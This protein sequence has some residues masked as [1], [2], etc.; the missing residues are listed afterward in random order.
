MSSVRSPAELVR[1]AER[2]GRYLSEPTAHPYLAWGRLGQILRAQPPTQA[3][4]LACHV[5]RA[6]PGSY[7]QAFGGGTLAHLIHHH[8]PTLIDW[9]EREA[10][11]DVDFLDALSHAWIARDD[12]D[13]AM[14]ARL[15][16]ATGSLIRIV[17]L[18]E[19]D[20]R[21]RAVFEHWVTRRPYRRAPGP[22]RPP[23]V[24]PSA[25]ESIAERF[26]RLHPELASLPAPA[27][28]A[29]PASR[30]EKSSWR[31]RWAVLFARLQ[32]SLM[33]MPPVARYMV[34]GALLVWLP[35]FLATAIAARLLLPTLV[36]VLGITSTS[37]VTDLALFLGSVVLATVSAALAGLAIG[38]LNQRRGQ[39]TG[40]PLYL[41]VISLVPYLTILALIAR[42]EHGLIVAPAV[43][44]GLVSLSFIVGFF[45]RAMR[46][47]NR[48]RHL[49]RQATTRT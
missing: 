11:R 48:A 5:I 40:P 17:T 26:A 47:L 14:L 35:W 18:S 38:V 2:Y 45:R 16:I 7:L 3:F 20:A 46:R 41:A 37:P 1:L 4:D 23:R 32:V 36:V 24:R 12:L 49:D 31:L 22:K 15:R 25:V 21:Y 27:E 13:P 19:R 9:I 28:A 43:L 6:L 34:Q 42:T 30:P 33:S 44:I 39:F 29:K 8:G 10:W